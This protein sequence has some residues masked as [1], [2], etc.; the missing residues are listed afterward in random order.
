MRSYF[1]TSTSFDQSAIFLTPDPRWKFTYRVGT[2]A[3]IALCAIIVFAI[4]AF[5]IWPYKA[6]GAPVEEVF[7]LLHENRL[8]GLMSLELQ[9]L[10]IQPVVFL[11]YFALYAALK[12]I[13]GSMAMV[14]L[15]LG[16]MGNVLMIFAR[17]VH[18][19]VFLSDLFFNTTNNI[20][21][22]RYL[23]AGDV[24]LMLYEGTAWAWSTIFAGAVA[25]INA[26]LMWQSRY[27]SRI[28]AV[29]GVTSGL[30]GLA[31][32]IPGIGPALS[33]L[34]TVLSVI[35]SIL[36]SRAFFSFGWKGGKENG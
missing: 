7:A 19:L 6:D 3:C 4:A 36:L 18:E 16:I 30:L 34:A 17:P 8:A 15:A 22:N 24:Y 11:V 32:F 31:I 29:I 20:L 13:N 28:T 12:Q 26:G 10:L 21:K 14:A 2:G 9:M 5:F 1:M 27:F 33:L 35:W 23:L 25:V